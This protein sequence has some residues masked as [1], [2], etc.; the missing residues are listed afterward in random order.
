MKV[1]LTPFLVSVFSIN[2][3]LRFEISNNEDLEQEISQPQ[4]KFGPFR[5]AKPEVLDF[6]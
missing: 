6:P 2:T 5:E 1:P 3:S 4:N